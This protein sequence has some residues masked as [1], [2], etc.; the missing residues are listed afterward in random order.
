MGIGDDELERRL[1]GETSK[2]EEE[3]EH[4]QKIR[5]YIRD[6]PGANAEEIAMATGIDERVIFKFIAQGKLV[7]K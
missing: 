4:F 5:N 7:K 1:R 6:N 2:A 3:V